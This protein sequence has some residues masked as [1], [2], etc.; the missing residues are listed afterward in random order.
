MPNNPFTLEVDMTANLILHRGARQVSRDEL[1]TVPT[2]ARTQSWVPIPHSR[3]VDGVQ[4]ALE[5]SGLR[6]VSERHGL[7]CDGTRYFGLLEIGHSTDDFGLLVGLRN[8]HDKR[9]P[10]GLAVG[11]RMFICDNLS[12]SSEIVLARKHTV[13]V[14]R[15][16]PQLI[17]RAVGQLG[18][19]RRNQESRFAAYKGHELADP[20]AHDL[21]IQ[22][23]DAQVV[24][25]T[26]VP[27]VLKEWREPRHAEFRQGKTAWRLFNAFTEVLKGNME[28]LPRRTQAL[29]G[30]N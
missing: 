2:P 25:V 1:L 16:L 27:A 5:S 22:A 18:T 7:T 29:H 10:A 15:D 23:F 19:H 12:F 21:V 20:Q 9:F 26:Q 4:T 11:A 17:E 14:E 28:A 24:P 30:L 13:H 8:S 3:L 6:V